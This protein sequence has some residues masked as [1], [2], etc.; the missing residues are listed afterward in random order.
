[1]SICTEMSIPYLEILSLDL[2]PE[3][4]WGYSEIP[5]PAMP[6][7]GQ[8]LCDF[9]EAGDFPASLSQPQR[10]H[11]LLPELRAPGAASRRVS[12]RVA[13]RAFRK[14]NNRHVKWSYDVKIAVIIRD[15]CI[16][17]GVSSR[18]AHSW[19][20]FSPA[21]NLRL[22]GVQNGKSI[23]RRQGHFFV[24]LFVGFRVKA[25]C[26]LLISP[27][28]TFRITTNETWTQFGLCYVQ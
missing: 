20:S 21:L 17:I 5:W 23:R 9:P 16:W 7:R 13:I 8:C 11:S 27:E 1:M 19:L 6:Y 18:T 3:G 25:S 2:L 15:N 26:K 4:L 24:H 12:F 14:K 10:M 22:S 28:K